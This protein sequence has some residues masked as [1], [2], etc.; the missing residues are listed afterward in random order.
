VTTP[1]LGKPNFG[2]MAVKEWT[3][4]GLNAGHS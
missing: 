4:P 2:P 1:A 3:L